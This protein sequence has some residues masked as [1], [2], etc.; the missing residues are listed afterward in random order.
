MKIAGMHIQKFHQKLLLCLGLDRRDFDP[1]NPFLV[2]NLV[3]V[4]RC[5]RVKKQ[6]GKNRNHTCEL[7]KKAILLSQ[8][9]K[10]S[11]SPKSFYYDGHEYGH[12]SSLKV[13]RDVC[14]EFEV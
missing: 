13:L 4:E 11:L 2:L 10:L 3:K 5:V 6:L 9:N 8:K 12:Y 7:I 1:K 14:R